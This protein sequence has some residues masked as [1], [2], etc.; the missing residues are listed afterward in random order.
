[1]KDL[2]EVSYYFG[3]QITQNR[4]EKTIKFGSKRYIKY[5]FTCFGTENFKPINT[6]LDSNIKSPRMRH[7]CIS[8]SL[9]R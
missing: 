4:E 2:E 8:R 1:M 5:I 6:P 9:R 7:Q 3:M